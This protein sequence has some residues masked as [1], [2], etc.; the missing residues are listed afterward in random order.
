MIKWDLGSSDVM[1][2]V[3]SWDQSFYLQQRKDGRFRLCMKPE[4]GYLQRT[5]WGSL[6]DI[7]LAAEDGPFYLGPTEFRE[8]LPTEV[9]KLL[10]DADVPLDDN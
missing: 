8:M 9:E 5:D 7:V 2:S 3:M 6:Q 10:P 4:E 1:G